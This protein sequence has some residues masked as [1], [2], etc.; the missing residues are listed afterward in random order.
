[1]DKTVIRP[2][3]IE[4]A[5]RFN[6]LRQSIDSETSFML[7]EAGERKISLEQMKEKIQKVLDSAN[8]TILLVEYEGVLVGFLLARGGPY[9]KVSRSATIVIGVL[10]AYG[11]R[12][13]GTALFEKIEEW[14]HSHNMH[15]LQLGVMSSNARALALYK[16]RGFEIEGVKKEEMFLDGKWEDE[17]MLAKILK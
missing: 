13:I 16:E 4:D 12:G 3:T 15:R 7:A 10:Q 5:E 1:M 14:A 8:S 11:G 17:I 9:K 2:I 6:Q